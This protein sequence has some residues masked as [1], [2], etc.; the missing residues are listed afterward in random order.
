MHWY[1]HCYGAI[2]V[3][4]ACKQALPEAW[5]VLGGLSASGFAREILECHPQVD[6]VIRGDAERPLLMLAQEILRAS[7][8][9]GEQPGLADIPN[10]SYRDGGRV[11]ENDRTYCATTADLDRLNYV[12]VDYL[13]HHDQYYVHE[14]IVADLD[15]TRSAPDKS[16]FRGRWLC[17]ARGCRY[18]CSYCGGCR[19]AHQALAGRKG[20]VPRSPDRMVDDMRRLKRNQVIQASLSY[21]I[22]EMGESYWRALF[23][24]MHRGGIW[25][26][27]YNE[28]FQL[29]TRAF[30]DA[31]AR[32]VDPEHT[33][34]A[35]SPLSGSEQVRRL[36]GKRYSN[37]QLFEVLTYLNQYN[38]SVFCY[39]S[40]NLPGENEETIR[41]TVALAAQIH[42][43][44]PSS[45]LKILTSCHTVDPLSPMNN[46]PEAYGIEAHMSTFADYYAYCRD[47]QYNSPAARTELHR[48]FQSNA[49]RSL[50]RM[51]DLWDTA[52]LGREAN[53]WPVPP[54]W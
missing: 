29:P 1:E 25:I 7:S 52:R 34:V 26:S 32:S 40:L 2:D 28:F 10:L 3:A 19:S 30:I 53:W 4:Q 48:G 39:F 12:D 42:D 8:K 27:L 33:C 44:Y 16:A 41:E 51:A 13:E 23:E 18:E 15:R 24:G 6:L 31:F 20:I 14:Y 45:L 35:L 11:I 46:R 36:N 49:P 43:F 38:L 5:T 50:E 54:G 37:E 47:T 17:T 9:R 21:D 22:A